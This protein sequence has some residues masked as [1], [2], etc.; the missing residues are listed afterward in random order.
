M[1]LLLECVYVGR[2]SNSDDEIQ[3][4]S[5]NLPGQARARARPGVVV[6]V[7]PVEL[8]ML[9]VMVAQAMR[10]SIVIPPVI[11]RMV[12]VQEDCLHG[13]ISGTFK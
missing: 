7:S 8:V 10:E 13:N 1:A 12:M 3:Y 4:M 9:I 11:V 5:D 6:I 2:W